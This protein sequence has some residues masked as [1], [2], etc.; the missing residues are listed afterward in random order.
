MV[1]VDKE[2]GGFAIFSL[3]EIESIGLANEFSIGSK[4]KKII[5]ITPK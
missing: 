2:V 4:G 3:V 1:A 5:K